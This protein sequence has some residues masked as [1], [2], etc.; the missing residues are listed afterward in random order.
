[1]SIK[2]SCNDKSALPRRVRVGEVLRSRYADSG[3]PLSWDLRK[4][5]IDEIQS[6]DGE[7]LKLFSDG[8]QST[9]KPG[10]TIL[11]TE[12]NPNTGYRWTLYGIPATQ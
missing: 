8:G 7:A 9:P 1:M 5:G 6:S 2:P 4:E 3:R 12:G 10:W 11:L